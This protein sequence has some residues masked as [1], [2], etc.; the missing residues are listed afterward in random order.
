MQAQHTAIKKLKINIWT[1]TIHKNFK[2]ITY[3]C[4]PIW[5]QKMAW[6]ITIHKKLLDRKLTK[7][8]WQHLDELF[9]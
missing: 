9:C 8:H 6:H 4:F 7:E 1:I 2:D 3:V 5:W